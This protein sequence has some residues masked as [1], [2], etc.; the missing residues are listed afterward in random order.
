MQKIHQ[1]MLRLGA[2][3]DIVY[4]EPNVEFPWLA[5]EYTLVRRTPCA[6]EH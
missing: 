6:A 1:L 2:R 4:L 3:Y 5:V